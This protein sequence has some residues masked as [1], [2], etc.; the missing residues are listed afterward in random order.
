[1]RI[2]GGSKK[3]RKIS[4]PKNLKLRPTTD[5]LKESILNILMNKYDLNSLKVLDLYSGTGNISFEFCS[6][7]AKKVVSVE[8]D[9]KA[10]KFIERFATENRFTQMEIV[11]MDSLKFLKQTQF[12]EFDLIF[13]DPPYDYDSYQKIPELVF[14]SNI[15]AEHGSLIIE[16]DKYTS[17]SSNKN[18]IRERKYGSSLISIFEHKS[19][20][21]S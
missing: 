20:Q 19:N 4:P 14:E 10:S 18:F 11:N 2:I 13:A 16:H 7:S 17:F 21:T 12:G 8:I 3:S 6:H 5:R 15:L 9:R 1:M